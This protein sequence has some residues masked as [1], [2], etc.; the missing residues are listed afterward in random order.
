VPFFQKELLEWRHEKQA[1][2]ALLIL[3]PLLLGLA[4]LGGMRFFSW[5]TGQ[6]LPPSD[7]TLAGS[8]FASSPA[9][10]LPITLLLSIGII[11]RELDQGTLAWNLTKPLSRSEFLLGK[12]LSHT[13]VIWV[14][15]VVFTNVIS[16]VMTAIALGW[17]T[18]DLIAIVSSHITAL[19]TIAFWVLVCIL[20][21]FILKDQA[22]IIATASSIAAIGFLLPN[23]PS[24]LGFF[25]ELSESSLETIRLLTQ[26][27]PSNTVDWPTQLS[28][29][30]KPLAYGLYMAG[31][32]MA[33][34]MI[35]DRR[36]YQ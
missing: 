26:L 22:A 24:A 34:K 3:L 13:L 25:M 23:L 1:A 12:W 7:L 35:F 36:E 17:A 6:P 2:I 29:P 32:A 21:G 5:Q 10:I 11:P 4:S 19:C 15:G 18:P 16:F 14:V 31:I 30:F 33:I 8:F 20:L 28:T 27:Y 9:W